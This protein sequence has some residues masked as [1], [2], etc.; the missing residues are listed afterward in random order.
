MSSMLLAGPASE[1]LTLAEAKAFLR[2]DHAD[3]DALIDSLIGAA[4]TLVERATRR[5]LI[6][7]TWRLVRDAWPAGG[8][9]AVLPAPLRSVAAARVFDA[10]GLPRAIDPAVFRLDTASAP[11]I[12]GFDRAAV[13]EPGLRVAGVAIDVTVG[14]GDDAAAVPAPLVQA[15][16]LWLAHFHEHRG[17]ETEARTPAAIAALIAPYRV[18]AP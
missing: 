18:L 15:V 10:D 14:Y 11:G 12:A 16:R 13:P 5:A 4:R 6:T 17:I 3:E 2:V 9:I 7:Q 8:R 1:P